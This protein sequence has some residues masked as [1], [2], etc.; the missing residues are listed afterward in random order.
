M[1]PEHQQA[2]SLI[3]ETVVLSPEHHQCGSTTKDKIKKIHIL[4]VIL[5]STII[6]LYKVNFSEVVIY[7]MFQS[8]S[9]GLNK[10]KY[11][12]SYL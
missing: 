9:I 6:R 2:W 12:N 8:Q 1:P 5:L 4:E 3:T 10:S 11:I 7:H